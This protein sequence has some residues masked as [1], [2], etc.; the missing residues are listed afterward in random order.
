LRS[1]RAEV[2]STIRADIAE[3][4]CW[5]RGHRVLRTICWVLT[6]ENIA[7]VP[8]HALL[9]REQL[10]LGAP[11]YGVLLATTTSPAVAGLALAP[12]RRQLAGCH[13]AGLPP[14][15][16]VDGLPGDQGALVGELLLEHQAALLHHPPGGGVIGP[17]RADDPLQTDDLE[18]VP[19]RG[20][21]ALGGQP[22]APHRRVQVPADLELVL[23]GPAGQLVQPDLTTP[24]AG[25]L[26][27][28]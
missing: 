9:A 27:D 15:G 7:E 6:L 1:E 12:S 4:A 3:G 10:G 23:A 22:P 26:V 13:L 14:V 28:R 17:R 8:G 25:V 2:P 21:G 16:P 24:A 11:G 20:P 5:L 18:P 19:Q